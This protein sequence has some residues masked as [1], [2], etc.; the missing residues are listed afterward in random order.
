VV[1]VAGRDG[2]VLGKI[3]GSWG[4]PHEIV[5]IDPPVALIDSANTARRRSTAPSNAG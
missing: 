3:V 5:V 4:C 1:V 2:G